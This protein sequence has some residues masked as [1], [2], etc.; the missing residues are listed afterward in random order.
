MGDPSTDECALAWTAYAA[1]S[2]R[3]RHDP[4]ELARALLHAARS[5]LCRTARSPGADQDGPALIAARVF[6]LVQI[7]LRTGDYDPS[8]PAEQPVWAAL[9]R[10]L[11]PGW[12]D[13]LEEAARARPRRRGSPII[14]ERR[15]N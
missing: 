12:A 11:P 13:A 6:C 9:L 14:T 7:A 8:A 4:R 15:P 1:A 5:D 2:S 3:T 10:V